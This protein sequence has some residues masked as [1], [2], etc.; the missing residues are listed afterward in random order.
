MASLQGGSEYL[1]RDTYSEVEETA[2]D[3]TDIEEETVEYLEGK[4]LGI[5]SQEEIFEFLDGEN[6][7]G[8]RNTLEDSTDVE[9]RI[10]REGNDLEIYYSLPK[11]SPEH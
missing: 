5:A 4:L 7:S 6:P 8:I 1:E 3:Y 11:K 2:E 10:M 9:I